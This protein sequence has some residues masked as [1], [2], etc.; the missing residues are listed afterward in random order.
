M[1]D[2]ALTPSQDRAVHCIDKNIAVS[3][4]AGSGKTRVLVRRFLYLLELGI[5]QPSDTVRPRDILAV[6]FTRKAAAEM[7]GRIREGIEAALAEG[8]DRAY[9]EQQLKGLD[10]AQIGTIHSFCSCLLR[11]NP[12]ECGLDPDFTVMEET[13]HDEFLAT[14]VRNRLRRLLHGQDPAAC[15]LPIGPITSMRTAMPRWVS[16][17]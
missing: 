9:W 17:K 11:T 7:R 1:A 14:E 5:R 8:K 3:A 4:G 6:T 15:L 10:Q 16:A 13:D 2:F 12:V